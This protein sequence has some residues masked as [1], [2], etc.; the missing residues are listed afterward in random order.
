LINRPLA[1][2]RRQQ[3]RKKGVPDLYD[4]AIMLMKTH[5]EKMSETGFAIILMKTQ[6]LI[7]LCH[8]IIENKGG[9]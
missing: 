8:Y 5:I 9:Y 3:P 1:E 2:I 7:L 6:L 4:S